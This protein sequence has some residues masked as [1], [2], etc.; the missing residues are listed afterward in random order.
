MNHKC[1]D[2]I[3]D[4][5]NSSYK[6]KRWLLLVDGECGPYV[7]IQFCPFCGEKLYGSFIGED[8]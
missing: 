2:I 7:I 5:P 3:Y 4:Y 8:E 6:E 1:E